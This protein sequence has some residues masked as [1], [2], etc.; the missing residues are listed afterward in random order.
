LN[1]QSK[2][3]GPEKHTVHLPK[4]ESGH[5]RWGVHVHE[6]LDKKGPSGNYS[7]GPLHI[8]LDHS[9]VK[10]KAFIQ[11]IAILR[12]EQLILVINLQLL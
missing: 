12:P 1:D 3:A 4:A 7:L 8:N 2:H 6:Y 10:E 5:Y 11:F 9:D